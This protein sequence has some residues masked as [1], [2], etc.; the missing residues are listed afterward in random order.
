MVLR[1]DRNVT[2]S[3]PKLRR[4]LA[5]LAIHANRVVRSDQII[6]ELWEDRPPVSATT[7]LQTYVYQLRKSLVLPGGNGVTGRLP[8]SGFVRTRMDSE[9]S[10]STCPGGYVLSLPDRALDAR[11]FAELAEQG[12]SQLS[13]GQVETASWTLRNALEVWN[14]PALNDVDAGPILR[15]EIRYLEELRNT[16]LEQRIEA[17]I[18]LGRHRELV[19]ELTGL[20]ARQP[21]HEGLQAK[22]MLTLY[23]AGR[24]SDALEVYRQARAILSTELGLEP[25]PELQRLQQ[26]ILNADPALGSSGNTG[27][28]FRPIWSVAAPAQ[29]PPEAPNVFGVETELDVLRSVLAATAGSAPA[30]AIVVGAPGSGK[31]TVVVCAAQQVRGD[32]PDGQFYA[33]LLSEKGEPVDASAVLASFLRA[34]GVSDDQLPA[35]IEERSQLFRSWTATRKVLVVLDDVASGE[36]L[37]PLLPSG[38]GCATIAAS[39]CRLSDPMIRATVELRHWSTAKAMRLLS[40]VLGEGRMK[41]DLDSMKHLISLCDGSPLALRTVAERL[42]KRPHWTVDRMLRGLVS[43]K[44]DDPHGSSRRSLVD[45]LGCRASVTA[46]YKLL[47]DAAQFAFRMLASTAQQPVSTPLAAELLG[48]DEYAAEALLENLVEF[49]LA[50]VDE[51]TLN[52]NMEFYYWV[53]SVFQ[54][55]ATDHVHQGHA[56]YGHAE[57]GDGCPGRKRPG[58]WLDAGAVDRIDHA[59][60][61]GELDQRSDSDHCACSPGNE[62]GGKARIHNDAD[63]EGP[64]CESGA[65]WRIADALL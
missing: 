41:R 19:G 27:P 15:A 38:R 22:L 31:T 43:R 28:T 39:R 57:P 52:G 21:M 53:K 3:A 24:R 4:V 46:S 8:S 32:Y 60:H 45:E 63:G 58:E 1:G 17:D 56:D 20:V 25:S 40:V 61:A 12:S 9:V 13:A 50:E 29:L 11:R 55:E 5:L 6:E 48:V 10:L 65:H 33:G 59:G 16:V 18:Q 51:V 64:E 30:V 54:M 35:G 37:A 36:Q 26:G 62:E 47:S 42:K 7:T 34:I 23:L 44:A 14:G 2:P 49:Q